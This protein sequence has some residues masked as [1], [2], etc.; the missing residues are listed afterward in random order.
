MKRMR[1]L[2]MATMAAAAVAGVAQTEAAAAGSPYHKI[3]VYRTQAECGRV[4]HDLVNHDKYA[5]YDC[6]RELAGWGLWV[7]DN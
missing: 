2:V 4:G 6:N 3:A 5:D 1:V 7:K